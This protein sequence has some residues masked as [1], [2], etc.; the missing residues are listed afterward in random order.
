MVTVY[1]LTPSTA[2][3]ALRDNQLDALGVTAVRL[4]SDWGPAVPGFG[5]A[6]L[7]LA[8]NSGAFAPWRGI[9]E[10]LAACTEF[11]GADGAPI[12][13]AGGALRLSAPRSFTAAPGQTLP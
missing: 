12:N 2:A 6:T 3:Q 7:T 13:G 11:R 4:A 9:F 10:N 5:A 1:T 8:F